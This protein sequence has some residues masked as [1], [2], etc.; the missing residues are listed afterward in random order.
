MVLLV[1]HIV[2]FIFYSE[3]IAT[4]SRLEKYLASGDI[5]RKASLHHALL[6]CSP[7]QSDLLDEKNYTVASTGATV[8]LTSSISLIFFY[9]SRLPSDWLVIPF[10]QPLFSHDATYV[11]H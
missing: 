9:C 8:T 10:Q 4:R 3:D 11:V 1:C 2:F 7:L 6:P 5:M